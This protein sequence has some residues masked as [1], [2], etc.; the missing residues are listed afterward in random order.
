MPHHSAGLA[1][2]CPRPRASLGRGPAEPAPAASPRHPAYIGASRPLPSVNFPAFR[3]GSRSRPQ[4]FRALPTPLR[5]GGRRGPALVPRRRRAPLR[6]RPA[7]HGSEGAGLGR[8]VLLLLPQPPQQQPEEDGAGQGAPSGGGDGGGEAERAR[9]GRVLPGPA[10][11]EPTAG[12][13]GPERR[14]R[15][16][17]SRSPHCGAPRPAGRRQG[18]PA[19]PRPLGRLQEA[20]AGA[21][22]RLLVLPAQPV[23]LGRRAAGVGRRV[24]LRPAPAARAPAAPGQGTA[25]RPP[26]GPRRRPAVPRGT[27]CR[28]RGGTPRRE[29][30]TA[31]RGAPVP[32]EELLAT[33]HR[34]PGAAAARFA[35]CRAEDGAAGGGGRRRRGE[36]LREGRTDGRMHRESRSRP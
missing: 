34:L 3:R 5:C 2:A 9:T 19:A 6:L 15:A 32:P 30:G 18:G 1:V 22:P 27:Q 20:A 12:R 31:A 25:A 24:R 21:G 17:G 33:Q 11:E 29:G 14:R 10:V 28:R 8:A 26:R 35:H 7:P 4:T 23:L 16:G 13:Q 36:C